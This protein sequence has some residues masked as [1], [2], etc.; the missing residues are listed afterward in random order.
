MSQQ[1]R[2]KLLRAIADSKLV[3]GASSDVINRAV[4]TDEGEAQ[5]QNLGPPLDSGTFNSQANN[6]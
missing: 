2:D 3:R 1:L 6:Q 4:N 5:V